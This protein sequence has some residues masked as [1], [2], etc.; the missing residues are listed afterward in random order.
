MVCPPALQNVAL[1]GTDRKSE[2]SNGSQ[3]AFGGRLFT[4]GKMQFVGLSC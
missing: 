1:K 2:D 4:Q 3:N